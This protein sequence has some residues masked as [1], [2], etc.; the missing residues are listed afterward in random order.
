MDKKQFIDDYTKKSFLRMLVHCERAIKQKDKKIQSTSITKE[1]CDNLYYKLIH[2]QGKL[3][4]M[5]KRN[6]I[7]GTI[8]PAKS[9]PHS[10]NYMDLIRIMNFYNKEEISLDDME[11]LRAQ[12]ETGECE[13]FSQFYKNQFLPE[14]EQLYYGRF[15]EHYNEDETPLL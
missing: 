5:I 2:K 13:I 12:I 15:L 14:A 3:L 7:D 10:N 9:I 11:K 4:T 8:I 6:Y 1:E